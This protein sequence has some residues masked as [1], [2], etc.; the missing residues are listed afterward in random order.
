MPNRE[1]QGYVNV[2]QVMGKSMFTLR[3]DL[4]STKVK[5]AIKFATG[6]ALP[7]TGT[8]VPAS[9]CILAWM[10][11]DELLIVAPSGEAQEIY[12]NLDKALSGLHALLEDVS[13]ARANFT[14][15]GANVREVLAK[16]APMDTNQ[17]YFPVGSFNRTRFSQVAGAVFMEKEDVISLIC[18][19]SVQDYVFALFSDAAALGSEVF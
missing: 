16:L 1:F 4:A 8:C 13:D 10:S 17:A 9:S 12:S 18:F 11:P 5:V 14:L 2:R 7:K 6:V 3:A 19:R 15:T